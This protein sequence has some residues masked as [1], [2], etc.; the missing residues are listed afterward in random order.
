MDLVRDI[1]G[2]RAIDNELVKQADPPVY[3]EPAGCAPDDG[4]SAE[5]GGHNVATVSLSNVVKGKVLTLGDF[6]DTDA[7]STP[8]YC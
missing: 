3:S 2:R 1:L 7:V 5:T 8:S 6:I 4:G